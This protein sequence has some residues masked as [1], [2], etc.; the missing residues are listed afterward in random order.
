MTKAHRCHDLSDKDW[1][2]LGE[3]NETVYRG[4]LSRSEVEFKKLRRHGVI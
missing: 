4:L 3:P 1:A 2:L